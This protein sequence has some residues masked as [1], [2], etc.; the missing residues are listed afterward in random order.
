MLPGVVKRHCP[1]CGVRMLV[2][3]P[4]R[5]FFQCP[6]CLL[7]RGRVAVLEAEILRLQ[8]ATAMGAR[9]EAGAHTPRYLN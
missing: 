3:G 1:R 9:N 7:V 6:V 8:M 2:V 4:L 5:Q